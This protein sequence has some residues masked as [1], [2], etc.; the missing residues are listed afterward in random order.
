M[1]IC[2]ERFVVGTEPGFTEAWTVREPNILV[3]KKIDGKGWKTLLY[4]L[5]K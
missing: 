3:H 1:T 2:D 4:D 5:L